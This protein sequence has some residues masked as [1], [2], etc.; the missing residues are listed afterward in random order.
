MRLGWI[1]LAPVVLFAAG[2]AQHSKEYDD[3]WAA[4]QSEVLANQD[5]YE[6]ADDQRAEWEQNA[7]EECMKKKGV[8][9]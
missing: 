6:G 3:A 8:T 2:C 5:A 1:A 9:S 4:C 7:I